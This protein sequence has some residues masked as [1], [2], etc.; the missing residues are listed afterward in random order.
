M[1]LS[2]GEVQFKLSYQLSPIILTGGIAA[3]IPGGMLPII[4]LT[5]GLSFVDG[6]LSGGADLDLDEYFAHFEPLPGSTLINQSIGK[7]PFANQQV[8][9]NAVIR[10]PLRVSMRMI[11]P[12]RGASGY[13]L[14]LA[15]MTT[16]QAVIAQHNNSGGTYTIATPSFFYTNMVMSDPGMTDTSAGNSQQRQNTYQLDFEQPLLTLQD[17]IQAQNNLMSQISAGMPVG[18]SPSWSGTSPTVGNP[19]SLGA[20]GFI[21]GAT[22]PAGTQTAAPLVGLGGPFQASP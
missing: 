8:A 18:A 1:S 15:T 11:C 5:Q 2:A 21:P 10:Q 3:A 16:L 14:K 7:Y 22:G 19:A 20:I 17:A 6:L 12:A 13:A 9:A 4:L